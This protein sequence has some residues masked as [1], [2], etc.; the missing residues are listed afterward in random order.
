MYSI[1]ANVSFREVC[2]QLQAKVF[3]GIDNEQSCQTLLDHFALNS[4][5]TMKW[6]DLPSFNFDLYELCIVITILLLLTLFIINLLR[7]FFVA[8][9]QLL[10][11][12]LVTI[13]DH[14]QMESKK[15]TKRKEKYA[16]KVIKALKKKQ[17]REIGAGGDH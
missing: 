8:D 17:D 4:N 15:E 9:F 13:E 6:Y 12:Q 5:N 10:L 3:L 14:L 2:D 7:I 16:R 11:S 1:Y